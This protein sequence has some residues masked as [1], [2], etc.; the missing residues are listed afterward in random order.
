MPTCKKCRICYCGV[1][2]GPLF[3]PCRCSGSIKYIHI[4]CLDKWRASEHP[5]AHLQCPQCLY[6]YKFSE[7][8]SNGWL[9][10]RW[11]VP[12]LT[13]AVF[14][15]LWSVCAFLSFLAS[16]VAGIQTNDT[17]LY[18][19]RLTEHVQHG[20]ISVGLMGL[21]HSLIAE[22]SIAIVFLMLDITQLCTTSIVTGLICAL[23]TIHAAVAALASDARDQIRAHVLDIRSSN[24]RS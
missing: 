7:V 19:M 14:C 16:I 12:L 24:L 9:S 20:L 5:N 8:G 11:A 2:Q 15:S 18:R 6:H 21:A 13:L 22:R 10:R 4:K 17:I 23:A 3:Q 1:D